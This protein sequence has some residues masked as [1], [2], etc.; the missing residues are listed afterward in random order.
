MHI[1]ITIRDIKEKLKSPMEENIND[2]RMKQNV[3]DKKFS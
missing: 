3:V 1:I 2:I